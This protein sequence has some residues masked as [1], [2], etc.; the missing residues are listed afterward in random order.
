[1]KPKPGDHGGAFDNY[2]CDSTD[3]FKEQ[4]GADIT[5]NAADRITQDNIEIKQSHYAITNPYW[6]GNTTGKFTIGGNTVALGPLCPVNVHWHLGAEHRSKGE[7]DENGKSPPVKIDGTEYTPAS[8]APTRRLQNITKAE[9]E[10]EERRLAAGQRYGFACNKYD[11][12]KPEWTKPYEWKHCEGMEVGATYEVHWPHSV[13]GACHTPWQYQTPFYDGVLCGLS[14]AALTDCVS[15]PDCLSNAVGVQG[16]VFTIINDES[17]YYPDLMRGMVVSAPFFGQ[18]VAVYTGSSTGT[19]RD[20]SMCSM[21]TPIT[22]Q[23]D[24]KCHLIS[25]SSFDKLCADM[26]QQYDDMSGDLHAHGA[27]LLVAGAYTANNVKD[28]DAGR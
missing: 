4:S 8:A 12:T 15:D 5:A 11:A 28:G 14:N 1:M 16:Q 20:N 27:R 2:E 3:P 25:A 26:K 6:K 18:D 22:W 13:L 17:Y 21:Y 19:S 23:V 24:R 7:F 10:E 9:E